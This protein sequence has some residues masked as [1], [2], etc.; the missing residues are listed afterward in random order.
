MYPGNS[1]A[2]LRP[3]RCDR[4][5]MSRPH[6]QNNGLSDSHPFR[7]RHSQSDLQDIVSRSLDPNYNGIFLLD[8]QQLT[9]FTM[10]LTVFPPPIQ[11]CSRQFD[12]DIDTASNVPGCIRSHTR[13]FSS[14][15]SKPVSVLGNEHTTSRILPPSLNQTESSRRYQSPSLRRVSSPCQQCSFYIRPCQFSPPLAPLWPMTNIEG[16][17]PHECR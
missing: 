6:E 12:M 11:S 16:R 14:S 4:R 3:Y 8:W 13:L 5:D 10:P 2:G 15:G 17:I 1:P 7:R 9:C